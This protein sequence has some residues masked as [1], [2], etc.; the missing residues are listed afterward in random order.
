[1]SQII[2][3]LGQAVLTIDRLPLD[4]PGGCARV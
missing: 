2:A 3:R 4:F 1:M